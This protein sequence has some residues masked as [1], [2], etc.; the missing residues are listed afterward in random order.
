[1]HHKTLVTAISAAF[2][3]FSP[4]QSSA[5]ETQMSLQFITFPTTIEPL[6]VELLLSE[7]R[8]MELLVPSNELGPKVSVPRLGSLV[9]GENIINEEQKPEFKIYGQGKPTAAAKQLV[10]L[11]RKGNDMASGIE[12]RT[13]SSDSGNFSGGKL[14]F[15]NAAK[16]DIA[17]IAGEKQFALK[18]GAQTII[19]PNLEK[20]GR[21][22]EVKFWF[23]NNGEAVPFFNSMWPV[24]EQFR[25]LVFFYHNPNNANKIQIHSFRDFLAEEE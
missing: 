5:Q 3:A 21:L 14:L 9:L 2:V 17:G 19:K 20:N 13:I 25:G 1:M 4:L 15:V 23:N 12:V 11:I 6:K 22:A 24:A 10:L 16:I 18:P 7:G 8:T